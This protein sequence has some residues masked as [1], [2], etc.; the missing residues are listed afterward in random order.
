MRLIQ[1]VPI[2][3]EIA[4]CIHPPVRVGPGIGTSVIPGGP[5]KRTIGTSRRIGVYIMTVEDTA[6]STL[7]SP[8]PSIPP[9][10]SWRR[11][12]SVY[13]P[14]A[15]W[16]NGTTWEPIREITQSRVSTSDIAKISNW[17][18]QASDTVHKDS[19]H[20]CERLSR[21]SVEE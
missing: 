8:F 6:I 20:T 9:W 4:A 18:C 2:G 15:T 12:K 5:A 13:D 11:T 17:R 21:E 10:D 3:R 7:V 19:S 14:W 1:I 16:L